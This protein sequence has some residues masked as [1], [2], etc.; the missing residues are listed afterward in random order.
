MSERS[1]SGITGSLGGGALCEQIK[2]VLAFKPAL[3]TSASADG[4]IVDRKGYN[5]ADIDI[6]I[7]DFT[8]SAT[9]AT[10]IVEHGDAE[11]L[12]DAADV[13]AAD[14]GYGDINCV[15]TN[16][17]D[18]NSLKRIK[19]DLRG[20]KRYF[21]LRL[22]RTGADM[23]LEQSAVAVLGAYTEKAPV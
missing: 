1:L 15:V 11:N 8:G 5:S 12:S 2:P 9:L 19:L 20:L 22:D 7:G 3:Q 6:A 18:E 17:T 13:V 16:G 10:Y 21:R 14:V 23:E 4:E